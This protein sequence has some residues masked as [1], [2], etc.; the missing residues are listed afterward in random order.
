MEKKYCKL[1]G[2]ELSEQQIKRGKLYCGRSCA[3]KVA[4][5]N[6]EVRQKVS[7]N[8]K[9]ALNRP[10]VKERHIT[11]IR[12]AYQN[13]EYKKHLSESS[14]R[15]L[16]RP[17][18]KAKLSASQKAVWQNEKYRQKVSAIRKQ[19]WAD[20]NFKKLMSLKMSNKWQEDGYK[21]R[22]SKSISEALNK[23]E[24][25]EKRKLA[26]KQALARPETKAKQ[27]LASKAVSNNK[28]VQQKIYATKKKNGTLN[29]SKPEQYIKELLEQKFTK[30]LFQHKSEQYPFNCDFY[31]EDLDLYV[32]LHFHWTH[33][34]M[35]YDSTNEDCIEQ[36]NNWKEKAKS[37]KFYERA[38]YAWTD[39]DVRKRQYAIDNKL[40]WVAFYDWHEFEQ[41]VKNYE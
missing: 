32:E 23:P 5:Q 12:K 36:L 2:K 14:K 18:T 34:R 7:E 3:M 37:S 30:I 31:I 20:E 24:A 39:L 4:Y 9:K 41:W 1:C 13:P 6:P 17:E 26:I 40:N 38:I 33:G 22:V 21:E 35:P 15:A 10:D 11:G 8:T 27:R 16:A 25:K 29:T 19:Q 28:E